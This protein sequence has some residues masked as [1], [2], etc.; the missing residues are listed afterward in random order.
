MGFSVSISIPIFGK[1]ILEE[2][3]APENLD[4][5]RISVKHTKKRRGKSW[6]DRIFVFKT[7]QRFSVAPRRFLSSESKTRARRKSVHD[8]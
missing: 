4:R 8:C 5:V 6:R 7:R 2:K 1:H 3:A